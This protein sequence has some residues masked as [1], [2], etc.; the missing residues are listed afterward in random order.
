MQPRVDLAKEK[1]PGE[2][3]EIER[4]KLMLLSQDEECIRIKK[5]A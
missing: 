5:W 3:N 4:N 1:G 2:E